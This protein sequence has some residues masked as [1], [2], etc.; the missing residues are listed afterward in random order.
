MDFS[1]EYLVTIES[2]GGFCDSIDTF[3]NLLKSYSEIK[4][5][6]GK[7]LFKGTEIIYVIKT[8]EIKSQK[9]RYFHVNL[10]ISDLKDELV[11]LDLL[12]MFRD[13]VYKAKGKISVLWDDF[14]AYYSLQSYPLIHR[15]E[16][17]LRKLISKFMLSNLGLDW[18]SQTVPTEVEKSIKNKRSQLGITDILHDVDFIQLSDF[19][20]KPYQTKGLASLYGLIE[21][22]GIETDF[23]PN[24]LTEYIPK[25]NWQRYFSVIVDCNDGYLVKRWEKLYELRCLIA[26]NTVISKNE[27]LEIQLLCKELDEKF[28]EALNDL[29]KVVI[30]ESDIE[31]LH[32][33]VASNRSE[34]N[35]EFL[36]AWK[37]LNTQLS[38]KFILSQELTKE[39]LK[40]KLTI[41]SL[42]KLIEKYNFLEPKTIHKINELRNIRHQVVHDTSNN[43]TE[44]QLELKT[45]ELKQLCN[46]IMTMTITETTDQTPNT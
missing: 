5:K 28:I 30:P 9:Q 15:T 7:I 25:S 33:N 44:K 38:E 19:L 4:I 2:K 10:T 31:I 1:I 43:L 11:F 41:S 36:E 42:M 18:S 12:R 3:N 34:F 14:S 45:K 37:T 17:L 29:E 24:V 8:D 40:M 21:K 27:F 20:F 16:N 22:I 6:N 23:D 13:I 32:E 26:H 35:G 39:E 46:E